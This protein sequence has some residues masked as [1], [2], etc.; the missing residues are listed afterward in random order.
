TDVWLLPRFGDKKPFAYL[1]SNWNESTPRLSPDG[2]WLAYSSDEIGRYEVYVQTF[3]PDSGSQPNGRG[4]WP[5]STN[6]G[7]RPVWSRDGKE[8]YFI[9][10]DRKMMA[11]TVNNS[12]GEKFDA[13]VPKPLFDS[14]ISGDSFET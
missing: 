2:K 13:S 5:V 3:A 8:L 4:K 9:S 14:R 1:N 12:A 10:A 6:G 11:I 7:T